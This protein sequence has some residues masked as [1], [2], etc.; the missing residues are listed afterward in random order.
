MTI[1]Q[2]AVVRLRQTTP[3]HRHHRT[4]LLPFLNNFCQLLSTSAPATP[5][6]YAPSKS[7]SLNPHPYSSPSSNPDPSPST[8][9]AESIE[10][11]PTDPRSKA[12]KAKARRS[13]LHSLS[14]PPPWLGSNTNEAKDSGRHGRSPDSHI[15]EWGSISEM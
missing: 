8:S 15:Y 5:R 11:P 6:P 13:V 4:T 10:R 3:R 9:A 2:M 14:L 1:T 12:Y 7:K